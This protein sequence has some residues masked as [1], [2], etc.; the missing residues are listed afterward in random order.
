MI[1][2]CRK[3]C[4]VPIHV[5]GGGVVTALL[6]TVTGLSAGW[7]SRGGGVGNAG[8]CVEAAGLLILVVLST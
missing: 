4:C 3:G 5:I 2:K 7:F 1:V 6:V 8:V